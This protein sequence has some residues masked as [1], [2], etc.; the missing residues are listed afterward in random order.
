M[1]PFPH[2]YTVT[3]SGASA[4]TLLVKS[5]GLPDLPTATP[6]EFD[7]PGD[8]WSPE[9]LFVGA[10]ASCYLLTFRGIA[11]ASRLAW[12]EVHCDVEG[13]LERI[14]RVTRFTEVHINV[15]LQV[16][17]GSDEQKAQQL[18]E[19]AK[20]GCLITNSLNARIVLKTEV[21]Q[22]EATPI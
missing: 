6:A 21:Y 17:P 15:K 22:L 16:P 2:H 18:L 13:V 1:Q 14:E 19:K 10:V 4:G 12:E 3:V 9:T 7:G 8:Q 11:Q 20:Q 5:T